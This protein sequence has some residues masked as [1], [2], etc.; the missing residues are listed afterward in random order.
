[1]NTLSSAIKWITKDY[2][3]ALIKSKAII[4]A[5]AATVYTIWKARNEVTF[6]NKAATIPVIFFQIQNTVYCLLY[7]FYPLEAI[8]F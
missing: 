5:F 8:R 1:M 6:N 7:S 3:G 2:K 4:I